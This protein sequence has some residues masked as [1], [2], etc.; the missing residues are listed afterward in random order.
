MFTGTESGP[1]WIAIS[2]FLL[3][4]LGGLYLLWRA[5]SIPSEQKI[6]FEPDDLESAVLLGER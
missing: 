6:A 2:I 4:V 5:R 1:G 3:L